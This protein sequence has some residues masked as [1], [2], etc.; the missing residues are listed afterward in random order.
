MYMCGSYTTR[1]GSPAPASVSATPSKWANACS[2][3]L[4]L[5][6]SDVAVNRSTAT[7]KL[8]AFAN[9]FVCASTK[10]SNAGAVTYKTRKQK[11]Y[12]GPPQYA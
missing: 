7:G 9:T 2:L 8:D 4:R 10:C 12:N 1:E 3:A 5:L 6:A 11:G